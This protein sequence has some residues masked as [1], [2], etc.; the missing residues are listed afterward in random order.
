MVLLYMDIL[1]II[2]TQCDIKKT[3]N[4]TRTPVSPLPAEGGPLSL[5]VTVTLDDALPLRD[6]VTALV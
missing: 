4:Q 6:E 1:F 2:G 3:K 5:L